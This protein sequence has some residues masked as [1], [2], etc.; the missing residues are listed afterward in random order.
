MS[1][2]YDFIIVDALGLFHRNNQDTNNDVYSVIRKEINGGLVEQ[3]EKTSGVFGF[4]RTL[5][6]F[7]EHFQCLS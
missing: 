2:L 4:L 6:Y 1:R 5:A 3:K 7:R